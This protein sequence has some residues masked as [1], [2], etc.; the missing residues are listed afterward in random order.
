MYTQSLP[1][2]SIYECNTIFQA[3]PKHKIHNT[4]KNYIEYS[5]DAER[6]DEIG[7]MLSGDAKVCKS[8]LFVLRHQKQIH[9]S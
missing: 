5:L 8:S 1:S 4:Y 2:Q 6:F 7:V 3:Q 9:E